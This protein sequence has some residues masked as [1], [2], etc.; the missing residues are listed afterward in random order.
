MELV[1]DKLI[2]FSGGQD[3]ELRDISGLALLLSCWVKSPIL[4]ILVCRFPAHLSSATLTPPPLAVLPLLPT[5]ARPVV[6]KH[7][8]VTLAQFLPIS[9]PQLFSDLLSKHVF[10]FLAQQTSNTQRSSSRR[11]RCPRPTQV[12]PLLGDIVP[13]VVKAVQRDDDEL[14]EGSLQALEAVL[15]YCARALAPIIQA[16]VQFIQRDPNYAGDDEDE[17][18]ADA[19]DDNADE[20]GLA[21]YSDDE[22]ASY[23]IRRAATKLLAAIV[24]THPELLS[25]LYKE[26]SPVLISRFG[27]REETVRLEVWATYIVL[28]NQ[29]SV[30]GRSGRSDEL[31]LKRKRDAEETME[32]EGGPYSLLKAQVPSLSKALLKQLKSPKTPPTTLQ[33]G[34]TVLQT[35]LD[36][37]LGSLSS[38]VVFITSTSK[39]IL[40][41]VPDHLRLQLTCLSFLASFFASHSPAIL[42]SSLPNLIVASQPHRRFPTSRLLCCAVSPAP[43]ADRLRDFPRQAIY[44]QAVARLVATIPTLKSAPVRSLR[45]GPLGRRD[46]TEGAVKVVTRWAMVGG[47]KPEVF[48][49]LDVLLRS[50]T[51]GP[52]LVPQVKVYLSTSDI[53]LLSQALS[54]LALLLELA[55]TTTFPEIESDLLPDVYRIAHSPLVAGTAL[56]SLLSFFAALVPKADASPANVAKSVAQIVRNQQSIAAGTIAQ[57]AK[58]IRQN[59]KAQPATVVLSLLILG[60]LGR[61][62]DMSTQQDIFRDSIEHFGSEQEEIRAAAST[63]FAAGNIAIGILQ[64]FL[65]AIIKLVKSDPKKRLLSLHAP[66][67][68]VRRCLH[69][70]LEGVVVNSVSTNKLPS[71]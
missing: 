35:L 48:Q 17:E 10:P 25:S 31:S 5:Y 58:H 12:A 38:H 49:G 65:P 56:D 67:E 37:L 6:R 71:E 4:S 3:E 42:A 18:M 21:E 30:Y 11:C 66:K 69:G 70:Q 7:A 8:I 16:G 55:P 29:T 27:D 33:A 41:Q 39:S 44:E 32:V 36:V 50:Y 59:A 9:Q 57:Y 53:P 1:V 14:R 43:S 45:W 52:A 40:S 61:F 46:G 63:S 64:Q 20:A 19:D 51:S 23:K 15:R 47:G 62:I 2:D 13:G 34:F 28:P 26:V 60:E 22:D 24:G 68:V 54:L